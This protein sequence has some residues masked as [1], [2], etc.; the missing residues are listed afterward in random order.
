DI[1]HSLARFHRRSKTTSR[2]SEMVEASF[3]LFHHLQSPETL[4]SLLKLCCH[5]LVK[6]PKKR[7]FAAPSS[8]T[9][10]SFFYYFL[11]FK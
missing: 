11:S 10:T 9:N 8:F 5:S 1:R 4:D 2:S 3:L 6:C 7:R